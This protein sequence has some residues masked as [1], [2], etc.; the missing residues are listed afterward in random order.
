[1]WF[2]QSMWSQSAKGARGFFNYSGQDWTVHM[3][4]TGVLFTVVYPMDVAFRLRQGESS[5][6]M[7]YTKTMLECFFTSVLVS[8]LTFDVFSRYNFQFPV[9][10]GT[11]IVVCLFGSFALYNCLFGEPS[12]EE[13]HA[14]KRAPGKAG[15][16]GAGEKKQKSYLAEKKKVKPPLGVYMRGFFNKYFA[17]PDIWPYFEGFSSLLTFVAIVVYVYG[18]NVTGAYREVEERVISS[19]CDWTY[20]SAIEDMN[21][22]DMYLTPILIADYTLRFIVERK[23][24]LD[25]FLDFFMMCDF[26]SISALPAWIFGMP[27][28]QNQSFGFLKFLRLL[29]VIHLKF[30]SSRM[31]EV[32]HQVLNVIMVIFSL[33]FCCAGLMLTLEYG[34]SGEGSDFLCWHDSLYFAVASLTT[35]GYGDIGPISIQGR[36]LCSAILIFGV[37]TVSFQVNQMATVI[38]QTNKYGGYYRGNDSAPH[39][40]L[41]GD[42]SVASVKAFLNEFYHPNHTLKRTDAK[43]RVLLMHHEKPSTGI[44]TLLE[45]DDEGF[46]L[47][48]F[49]EGTPTSMKDL[50]RAAVRQAKAVFIMVEKSSTSPLEEDTDTILATLAIRKSNQT[51]NIY[52]QCLVPESVTHLKS[53]GANFV[54]CIPHMRSAILANSFACPGATAF[55]A[56]L[57][58]SCDYDG[59]VYADGCDWELY[60]VPFASHFVDLDFHRAVNIIYANVSPSAILLGVKTRKGRTVINPGKKYQISPGD[61]GIV[62]AVDMQNAL[63]TQ[64]VELCIKD[65]E[66]AKIEQEEEEAQTE[67]KANSDLFEQNVEAEDYMHE[68][69]MVD[70][71]GFLNSHSDE[72][73]VDLEGHVIIC[74]SSNGLQNIIKEARDAYSNVLISN[75]ANKIIPKHFHEPPI[76]IITETSNKEVARA[77]A[78]EN[79]YTL[80]ASATEFETLV[81][82]KAPKAKMLTVLADRKVGQ[83]QD[84]ADGQS[85]KIALN[86]RAACHAAQVDEPFSVCELLDSKNT[87]YADPTG[88]G[89]NDGDY[90][91]L[92]PVFAEGKIYTVDTQDTLLCQAYYN[93]TIYE[94]VEQMVKGTT[95]LRQIPVP[96]ELVGKT[97]EDAFKKYSANGEHV[98]VGLYSYENDE[99]ELEEQIP[100]AP[101]PTGFCKNLFCKKNTAKVVQLQ[102][103]RSSNVSMFTNEALPCVCT[104]PSRNHVLQKADHLIML[105]HTDQ[106]ERKPRTVL[107]QRSIQIQNLDG[108]RGPRLSIKGNMFG[109]SQNKYQV[110]GSGNK[111]SPGKTVHL[112]VI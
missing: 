25:A 99:K 30:I 58:R 95:A 16:D 49:I 28:S 61:F 84:A 103:R 41:T 35:V 66:R 112:G 82:A 86:L 62:M 85:I 76:V 9:F 50:Q 111:Y 12:E 93:P 33:F 2:S 74:G 101:A 59:S 48:E 18:V 57:C 1:M 102:V 109:N 29:R 8:D 73:P 11:M 44:K 104:N 6:P 45:D 81:R 92:A 63:A 53:A 32:R 5:K 90:F 67:E 7:I 34:I 22:V 110:S 39:V 69:V 23:C 14:K 19:Q 97:Y 36:V 51:V 108:N 47:L 31:T 13:L 21:K 54:D 80:F 55:I 79:V 17:H 38:Q 96:H 88:W 72:I 42:F 60:L 43:V 4:L 64:K 15:E 105:G 87:I 40:I 24:K 27:P 100:T 65:V 78:L 71:D 56:N 77:R 107:R 26:L 70:H 98:V 46:D 68:D 37:G 20:A 83:S 10:I 75:N 91:P 106:M 94:T 3:L 89:A 52:C